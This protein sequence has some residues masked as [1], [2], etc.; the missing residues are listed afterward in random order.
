[1]TPSVRM[2]ITNDLPRVEVKNIYIEPVYTFITIHNSYAQEWRLVVG[3]G[4]GLG[5]GLAFRQLLV[6][7]FT[8]NENKSNRI[9][10]R[11]LNSSR[12]LQCFGFFL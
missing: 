2:K 10:L 8:W 1:M 7:C 5:A 3:L 9:V 12:F 11:L 6:T 4:A